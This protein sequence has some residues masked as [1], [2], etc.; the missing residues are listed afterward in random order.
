MLCKT[1]GASAQM[2][3]AQLLALGL[4]YSLKARKPGAS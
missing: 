1:R 3:S 2:K 4:L